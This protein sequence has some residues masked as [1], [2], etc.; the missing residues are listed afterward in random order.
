VSK[1]SKGGHENVVGGSEIPAGLKMLYGWGSQQCRIGVCNCKFLYGM[2]NVVVSLK[3]EV[4]FRGIAK[5][6]SRW[7]QYY[8]Y[9]IA[10]ST[11]DTQNYAI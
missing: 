1:C 9:D 7:L 8:G 5:M 11:N 3:L 2:K 4:C 10:T 6:S